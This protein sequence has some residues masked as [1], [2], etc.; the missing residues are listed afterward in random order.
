MT[1]VPGAA[2]AVIAVLARRLRGIAGAAR[3]AF[4]DH[5]P[6]HP[7]CDHAAHPRVTDAPGAAQKELFHITTAKGTDFRPGPRVDLDEVV[8]VDH[9]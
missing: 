9:W 7:K 8:H 3:P 2:G 4:F 5:R 6:T 1:G